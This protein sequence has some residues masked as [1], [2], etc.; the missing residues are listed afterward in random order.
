MNVVFQ[1]RDFSEAISLPET[2]NI[3]VER[4]T[5][6]QF[7]GP[8]VATLRADLGREQYDLMQL[9]RAPVII[10]DGGINLWWGYVSRIVAPNG[11]RQRQGMS[12]DN[13]YNYVVVAYA[14]G[15]TSAASNA[16]SIAE[17]GQKETRLSDVLATQTSAEQ[18]RD[19]YL[20]NHYRA[21]MELDLSGGKREIEIECR[22]W[23]STLGWKYYTNADNSNIDNAT[24]ISDIVDDAGQFL[25]GVDIENS[26]GITS[27]EYRDGTQTALTYVNQLLNAGTSNI[28]PLLA[29]VG[30]DRRLRVYERPAEPVGTSPQY[31]LTP[32]N[33]LVSLLGNKRVQDREC[34]VAVWAALQNAPTTAP[35]FYTPRPFFISNSKYDAREDETVYTPADAF[36]AVRLA[37]Y[38]A[39]TVSGNNSGSTG[40]SSPYIP[41]PTIPTIITPRP[42]L[43]RLGSASGIAV[44]DTVQIASSAG[45]RDVGYGG[46]TVFTPTTFDTPT[47]YGWQILVAGIYDVCLYIEI[48]ASGATNGYVGAWVTDSTTSGNTLLLEASSGEINTSDYFA[49]TMS[50]R[51][52]LPTINTHYLTVFAINGTDAGSINVDL[53]DMSATLVRA[54]G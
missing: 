45:T 44:S 34:K 35:G 28:R 39:E 21:T 20:S 41:F 11:D 5:W 24:Q 22:G 38:I 7:G 12:L 26:A 27:N 3:Q 31:L 48:S 43:H 13:T 47:K 30:V 14:D 46:L 1:E 52:K 50:K 51:V 53:A 54:T 8:D 42:A 6:N 32:E 15:D 4:Y 25:T 33:K 10:Q 36:E 49:T 19:I 18:N 23:Y 29:T 37:K 17:Y 2:L 40:T 16:V 9:L